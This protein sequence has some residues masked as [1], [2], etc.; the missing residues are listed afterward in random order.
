MEA[1]P[2]EKLKKNLLD[3]HYNKY[4]QYFN[5]SIIIVFTYFIGL[6]ISLL[7]RQINLADS[8][9]LFLL[10]LFSLLF[11]GIMVCLLSYFRRRMG[12]IIKE[13]RKLNIK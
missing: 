9:H 6:I 10:I 13:M 1:E 12:K 3:L 8:R 4:L 2:S 5:T 7:T 11:L